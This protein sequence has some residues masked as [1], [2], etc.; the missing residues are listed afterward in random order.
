MSACD[1][2]EKIKPLQTLRS[3]RGCLTNKKGWI[4]LK[5]F[6]SAWIPLEQSCKGTFLKKRSNF[7]SRSD[8]DIEGNSSLTP[9]L[10]KH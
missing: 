6:Y 3:E 8:G 5:Q 2:T 7:W 10:D 1:E 9:E 4:E